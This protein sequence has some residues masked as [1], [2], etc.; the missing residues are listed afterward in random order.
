MMVGKYFKPPYPLSIPVLFLI[1]NRL[2]T[3]EKVFEMIRRAKPPRFY[4]ASDGPRHWKDGEKEKV[5]NVR[6][7][8]LS[9]IDWD[10]KVKTLFRDRN[11]GCGKAIS[12]AITWF[13]ENEEMGIILED[14]CL[15]R[16][17]FFWFC[18][19]LLKRYKDDLRV[20]HI[21]GFNPNLGWIRDPD[22]SYYFS[23][24]GFV[25]GW[26][27]WR[28]RWKN[29]D[30][31]MSLLDEILG[32]GYVEDIGLSL[33]KDLPFFYAIRKGQLDTWDFQ[34]GFTMAVNN[35][36]SI[37]P[38]KNLVKN[39]G[40][41]GGSLH[42]KSIFDM[43]ANAKTSDVEFPLRHPPFL[44]RDRKS[45]ER[46]LKKFWGAETERVIMRKLLALLGKV[47]FYNL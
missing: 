15:P 23:S 5:E 1:F 43:R 22:Y 36:L 14:D 11:L 6:R 10:C 37:I 31:N 45:D 16:L 41:G 39:I 8:V 24:L 19:E 44:I 28:D 4:V 20:W 35:G 25:W 34:W 7:Y 21:A 12:E 17:S 3:T 40:F 9:N 38:C 32:K 27:T 26:A 33:E 29:Y 47:D 18:E 46:F 13:F 42:T 2:D 30:F